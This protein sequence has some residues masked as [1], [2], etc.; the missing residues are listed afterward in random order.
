MIGG[1]IITGNTPKKVLIRGMGPVL[2]N[3]GISNFLADPVLELRG[4]GGGLITSNDNWKDSQRTE[5]QAT[6]LAP[7]DDRE[8]AILTTLT[9]GAY[10]ALLTGKGGT[11]GVGAVELY[12]LNTGGDS[13]F[14]NISTRGLVQTGNNV[15]I[16]GFILGNSTANEHVAVRGLG[17]SL[18]QFGLSNVLADPTLELRDSNGALLIANDDWETDPVSAA[19]IVANNLAPSNPK[20]SAIYTSLPPGAFTAVLAGKNG[21][22]GIG[23]VEVYNLKL[24]TL[25]Y[26]LDLAHTDSTSS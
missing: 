25:R 6:G 2:A 7:G 18:S 3:F 24:R 5:I 16:A 1:F 22:I 13:Q 10:T 15:L 14:G 21:G 9:P 17:P 4:S 26:F 12:D 8:A 23:T 19:A 11:V 20:E